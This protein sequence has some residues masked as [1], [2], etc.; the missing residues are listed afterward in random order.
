MKRIRDWI[1]QV[2]CFVLTSF[3]QFSSGSSLGRTFGLSVQS[4]AGKMTQ[5]VNP[6]RKVLPSTFWDFG[7]F[8]CEP[9][10]PFSSF[11]PFHPFQLV[12]AE[13]EAAACALILIAFSLWE[14][15]WR[16][17]CQLTHISRSIPT[18]THTC[19]WLENNNNKINSSALRMKLDD[20]LCVEY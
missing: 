15:A 17:T 18:P 19:V 5:D 7:W 6:V 8:L 3:F 10:S 4:I 1:N 14:A 16:I 11:E 2:I 9:I 20:C 13:R 12:F